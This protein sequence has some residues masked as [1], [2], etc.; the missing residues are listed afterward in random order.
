VSAR[1]IISPS[2]FFGRGLEEMKLPRLSS[3]A[4]LL[5]IGLVSRGVAQTY[6]CLPGTSP[7]AIVLK[8]Y[9]VRLVTGTDSESVV[10]RNRYQLPTVAASKVSVETS[11]TIC[12]KAG[13]AYHAAETPP[14]TPPISRTL[15]VVKVS[16][17]RYI[18]LDINELVGEYRINNVFDSKWI[19]L[20]GF[21][22]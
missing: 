6:T 3:A 21:T 7:D 8:D 5:L 12:N 16:T 17:T 1:L 14:G 20:I 22:S 4:G 11:A 19:Y 18:V 15:V 2:A 13:A 10:T 9:V